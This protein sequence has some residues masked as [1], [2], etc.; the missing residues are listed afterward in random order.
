MCCQ[1]NYYAQK[2]GHSHSKA[3]AS[4]D[5]WYPESLA[6][7]FPSKEHPQ[8]VFLYAL[9]GFCRAK[10][11]LALLDFSK[12]YRILSLDEVICSKPLL[13]QNKASCLSN[14]TGF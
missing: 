7:A 9:S 12:A 5:L 3:W 14:A 11:L 4:I 10:G 1:H 2:K 13:L 6:F 8:N